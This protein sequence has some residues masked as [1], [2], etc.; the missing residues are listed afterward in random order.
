[1]GMNA[2][3]IDA[4]TDRTPMIRTVL[5][6][7][8]VASTT[9][10]SVHGDADLLR[11]VDRHVRAVRSISEHHG[12]ELGA[13]VGDGVMVLFDD[14]GSAVECA[15]RLLAASAIQ[16]LVHVR[17]GLDHGEVLPYRSEWYVGLTLHVASR[18][19]HLSE[20]DEITMTDRC[21]RAA[22]RSVAVPPTVPREVGV[23]GL[24][25]PL[26]VHAVRVDRTV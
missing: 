8:I 9:Y 15:L 3:S 24:D 20:P 21:H 16:D 13:F 5:F 10:A 4:D 17:I 6:I 1:M 14:A 2:P 19:T 11:V 25:E 26:T 22:R 7:D 12:G 23:R 18:L